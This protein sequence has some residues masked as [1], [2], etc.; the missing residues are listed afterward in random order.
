MS[1]PASRA[2]RRRAGLASALPEGAAGAGAGSGSGSDA[3][4]GSG[5]GSGSE[6]AS[7]SGSV[8]AT[9]SA[10]GGVSSE[11]NSTRVEP[12]AIMSP[13]PPLRELTTPLTG[14]GMVTDALSVMTSTIGSSSFTASPTLTCHW[15]TSPSTTPSPMS[16]SLNTCIPILSPPA[17]CVSPRLCEQ[18]P[19]CNPIQWCV[20]TG[21]PT[22]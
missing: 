2:R 7:T 4:S 6:A 11:S 12:T 14:E 3:G 22:P 10:A 16:G 1:M 8:A 20:G 18:V 15:T 13:T 9:G 5:S 21:R 19:A 17:S